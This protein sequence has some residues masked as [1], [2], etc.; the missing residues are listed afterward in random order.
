LSSYIHIFVYQTSEKERH[1]P[2]PGTACSGMM[3]DL[4]LA[5]TRWY[6]RA[7]SMVTAI[8]TEPAVTMTLMGHAMDHE[9][10]TILNENKIDLY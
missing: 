4:P 9:C 5:K 3:S 10:H 6:S 1:I 7:C 8:I 2:I